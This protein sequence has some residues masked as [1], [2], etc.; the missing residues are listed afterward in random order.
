MTAKCL[1]RLNE[2][3]NISTGGNTY[4]LEMSIILQRSKTFQTQH[5]KHNS[6]V[7]QDGHPHRRGTPVTRVKF[8]CTETDIHTERNASTQELKLGVPQDRRN[9]Q[10]ENCGTQ[11]KI[12]LIMSRCDSQHHTICEL[13]QHKWFCYVCVCVT[14][15]L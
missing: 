4:D 10:R 5:N 15:T 2:N 3:D 11:V 9:K 13:R 8:R 7:P 1:S 14:R 6:G 12:C